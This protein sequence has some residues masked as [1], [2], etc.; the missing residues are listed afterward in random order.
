[1]EDNSVVTEHT[2]KV[3]SAYSSIENPRVRLLIQQFVKYLHEYIIEVKL[4]ENEWEY[5][6]EFLLSMSRFANET[7]NEF[8]LLADILGTSQL[9]ELINHPRPKSHEGYT[10]TGPFYRANAPIRN[11]GDSIALKNDEEYDY[12]KITGKVLNIVTEKPIPK[13]TLD[14]WQADKNGLYETQ[15]PSQPSMNLRGKFLTSEDGSFEFITIYPVSYPVPTDG[16]AGF[17]LKIANRLHH[18]PAHIHFV[19][20]ANGYQTLITEVF[21]K[22]DG[23]LEHDPVFTA[24]ESLCGNFINKMRAIL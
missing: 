5:I 17:L 4:L 20:S 14:V 8:I 1:M 3:I 15:D 11:Q 9:I 10:L 12:V 7:R 6:C 19:I 13:A 16:P 23:N 18:R 24:N 21:V 2:Q 22:G